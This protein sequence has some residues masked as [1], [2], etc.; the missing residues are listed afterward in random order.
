MPDFVTEVGHLFPTGIP[1][2]FF[3]INRV[4]RAVALGIELNIVEDEEFGFRTENRGIGDAGA[5]QIFLGALSQAARVAGVGFLGAGFGDG[6][7]EG[8]SG[9]FA[10]GI[11]ESGVGIGHGEHVRG[12]D[13]FPAADGGA[14]KAESFGKD[15]FGEFADGTGEML[16]GAEGID[17]LDVHHPG[18]RFLSEF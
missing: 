10:E 8:E 5:L 18:A 6:A 16:P 1:D 3:G 11:D 17:E 14:V 7:G 15:F 9:N 12:L 13:A 4:E 2:S